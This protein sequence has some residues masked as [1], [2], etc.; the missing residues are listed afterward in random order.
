MINGSYAIRI[1]GPNS[2]EESEEAELSHSGDL[3]L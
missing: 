2:D 1:F 3:D